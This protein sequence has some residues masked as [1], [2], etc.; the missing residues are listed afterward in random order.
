MSKVAVIVT[1]IARRR[2]RFL[3]SD[4]FDLFFHGEFP[5]SLQNSAHSSSKAVVNYARRTRRTRKVAQAHR[6]GLCTMSD[7]PLEFVDI[8]RTLKKAINKGGKLY[9]APRRSPGLPHRLRRCSRACH[10]ADVGDHKGCYEAYLA[11]G[12]E[13]CARTGDDQIRS[14]MEKAIADVEVQ[15]NPTEQ[16]CSILGHGGASTRAR[17]RS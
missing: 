15:D 14:I 13:I 3:T 12:R 17:A 1:V 10:A 9:S 7:A 4:T 8:L 11:A 6:H 2:F 16:V 5:R